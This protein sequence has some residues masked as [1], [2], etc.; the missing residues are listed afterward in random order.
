[1]ENHGLILGKFYPPHLGHL[2]LIREAKKHCNHLTVLVATLKRELIPG[3]LRFQWMKELTEDLPAHV[4]WVQD[5]NPQYPEED[6]IQFWEIWK[7]TILSHSPAPIDVLFTSE[8]YGDPLAKVLGTKHQIIDL[9]RKAVPIS[10]SKIRNN[11]ADYWEFIPEIERPFF[12]KRVVLTGSESVGKTVLS[13]KLANHFKTEWAPEFA[14]EYLDAKGRFVERDDIFEIAEG[15]LLSEMKKAETANRI[16]FLDTDL[17][18][19]KI[20]AE[21][22]FDLKYDWLQERAY[23][24][25][26]DSSLFLDIDIPWVEDPLRDLGDI[27]KEMKQKFI[28]EMNLAKRDFTLISGGFPERE[29]QAVEIV[30]A[31]LKE[32]MNPSYFTSKQISLRNV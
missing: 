10:A 21:H 15:H 1:M 22:Y 4:V 17:L 32:P 16:L 19:T 7:K 23:Q 24:L 2:H 9:E 6:P 27:R 31:I 29:K 18:T 14:R 3:S 20:Y 11:P 26:Y 13:E 8:S 25:Q 30:E 12:L 5:E 28:S